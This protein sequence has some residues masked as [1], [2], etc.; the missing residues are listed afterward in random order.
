ME[1]MAAALLLQNTSA[2]ERTNFL[3]MLRLGFLIS[4]KILNGDL[5]RV[6]NGKCEHNG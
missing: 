6:F 4:T 5:F 3:F 2:A 1:A